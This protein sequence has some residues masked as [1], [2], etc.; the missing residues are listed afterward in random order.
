MPQIAKMIVKSTRKNEFVRFEDVIATAV[1]SEPSELALPSEHT[2]SDDQKIQN[3]ISKV[4]RKAPIRTKL[5]RNTELGFCAITFLSKAL[6]PSANA[7]MAKRKE[8]A[9]AQGRTS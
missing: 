3:I 6:S 4:N 2:N 1:R 8:L 7:L 5:I 9:P